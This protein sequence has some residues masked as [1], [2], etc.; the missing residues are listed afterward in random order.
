MGLD[1]LA[2]IF[3]TLAQFNVAHF[4]PALIVLGVYL[5]GKVLIFKDWRSSIDFV[6]GIYIILVGVFNFSTAFYY[7]ILAWISY[8]IISV[9]VY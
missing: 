8:K 9:V 2:L 3:L 4:A 6:A 7:L 1:V 5:C